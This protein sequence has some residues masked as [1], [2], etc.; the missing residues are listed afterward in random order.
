M[1]HWC[2]ISVLCKPIIKIAFSSITDQK[3]LPK[4]F[5]YFADTTWSIHKKLPSL[6]MK[7]S[8]IIYHQPWPSH[9][10]FHF[11]APASNTLSITANQTLEI[12]TVS[13]LSISYCREGHLLLTLLC[14]A[15]RNQY[16]H[17]SI[18]APKYSR[19][20][21]PTRN[22]IKDRIYLSGTYEW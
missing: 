3:T 7:S 9:S 4:T 16:H 19:N 2:V 17:Y 8:L 12:Y 10:N 6:F 22:K 5:H 11:Y 20:K 15:W 21:H 1:P 13:Q 14:T 18:L